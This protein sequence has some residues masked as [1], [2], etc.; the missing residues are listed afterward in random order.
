MPSVPDT[1]KRRG[2]THAGGREVLDRLFALAY[3]ELRRSARRRLQRHGRGET[4]N[5]T[6]LVHETYLRLVDQSRVESCDRAHFLALASRAMRFVLVDHVRARTAQKRGGVRE[7]VPLDAVQIAAEARAMD[8]LALDEALERLAR[9]DPRLAQLI[10]Y[11]FFG[12][13]TYDDIAEVS[14]LSVPT[15]KRDWVRA[16][17]WLFHAMCDSGAA[18]PGDRMPIVGAGA[19]GR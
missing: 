14:G 17:A 19:S 2:E 8:L 15:V 3:D 10:E 9:F 7:Q 16:R 4:L 6:M 1:A 5:T 11:R 18:E 12:G 13:L